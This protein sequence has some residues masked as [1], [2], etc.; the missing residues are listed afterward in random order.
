[1]YRPFVTWWSG[2]AYG[3]NREPEPDEDVVCSVSCRGDV[4]NGEWV[5]DNYDG[6]ERGRT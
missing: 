2:L 6:G 3:L 5:V 1:M 4:E